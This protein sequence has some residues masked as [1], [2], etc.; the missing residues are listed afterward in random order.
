[1]E[2]EER[3]ERHRGRRN[4]DQRERDREA[5]SAVGDKIKPRRREREENRLS[6]AHRHSRSP[7]SNGVMRE[8]SEEREGE[9]DTLKR[10]SRSSATSLPRRLPSG[11]P[12]L[13][14]M[15]QFQNLE[16]H[17]SRGT[18]LSDSDSAAET[19]SPV[20]ST[21]DEVSECPEPIGAQHHKYSREQPSGSGPE[22]GHV[23][24]FSLPQ[25]SSNEEWRH[26]TQGLS[27]GQAREDSR[28]W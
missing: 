2:R 5:H 25:K 24:S 1:M 22:G 23:R 21:C 10:R 15:M 18:L 6:S 11:D 19:T 20:V 7:P 17:S 3:R 12:M 13:H 26:K 14:H 8:G 4:E 9:G 16:Y 28:G 27:N